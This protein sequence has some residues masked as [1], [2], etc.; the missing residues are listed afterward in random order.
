MNVS[1]EWLRA[2]SGEAIGSPEEIA[3]RLADRGYPVEDTR[4]LSAGLEEVVVAQVRDVQ[5]HPD[6]DRL[7]V[8]QVDGGAGVV[9]VVCGAP[10]VEANGWY[11]F[12]PVGA[13]LPGGMRIRK[14]QLR[15]QPSE[16]MLCSERELGLGSDE[17]GLM[18]LEDSY[19]P[20]QALVA[21]LG[22]DDV[23]LDV[24][25]TPN[26]SDLLSHIGLARELVAGGDASLAL[27]EIPGMDADADAASVK[28]DVIVNEAE[29]N[30]G[31]VT[32]RVEAEDLCPRYL[33]IRLTG[34]SVRPSPRWLQARLRAIGAKPINNVVDATNYLLHESGQ[35]LHAFNLDSVQD[36]TIVVRRA[37]KA[38]ALR[39][40]DRV[41]RRL[42]PEMLAICDAEK[43]IAVAG[44]MGGAD[45][46][47]SDETTDVLLE[48][49]LFAPVS[50]RSTGKAL[51][52]STDASYRFER[53]VDPEGMRNAIERAAR[54][55]VSTA[56]GS[57]SSPLLDVCPRP[58]SRERISLRLARIEQVLGVPFD[59]EAVKSLLE[60]LGL[61]VE[62]GETDLSVEVPGF[63]SYDITREVDLIEEIARTYGYDAFPETLGP[64]RLGSLPDH[65]LFRLESAV[66]AE[67]VASGLLEAQVPAFTSEE[68][69]E[70]EIMNPVSVE[71][72]F[73]RR[74]LLPGLV[75]RLDYNLRRANRDVRLFELGTV[76]RSG[77]T[78]GLPR[79]ET[80]VAAILY[81]QRA[82]T[83]WREG[84]APLDIWDL[85][86]LLE[87]ITKVVADGRWTVRSGP[88]E[89]GSEPGFDSGTLFQVADSEGEPRGAGGRLVGDQL[90]IPRWAEDVWALELALP[91]EP[92]LTPTPT[93]RSL[94]VHQSVDRDLA[95]LIP[96][97]VLVEEVLSLIGERGG[98][99][100]RDIRVFDVY[101][102]DEMPSE[103]RSV[104]VRLRFRASD[105]TLKDE[106]VEDAV[107]VVTRA[108]EEEL[109]VGFRGKQD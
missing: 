17:D 15:G 10:N 33:A 11:P 25:V 58:F 75:G 54:L 65:P 62:I 77:P 26:R 55:I 42:T 9:Q 82:P 59:A 57:I 96:R 23:R 45:S 20:G 63:R 68:G 70:V 84:A 16:G 98:E 91:A 36:R 40:L 6:A 7:R 86:A 69:G 4:Y 93:F 27:P 34:L 44:A 50:I 51:G 52:L 106:E 94:P 90:K 101:R 43:P 19:Q 35:P 49:A 29:V 92:G 32:V 56:G 102:G 88:R 73:L 104:A 81:G 1:V 2:C 76:F 18:V 67:M 66:R 99:H 72:A 60:P 61:S 83:H 46:E 53:G 97:N 78:G 109:S 105:R 8:C 31:G 14:V 64:F 28:V 30:G 107:R 5:P 3:K 74:R 95:L 21:A 39:T 38:E 100:L 13:A 87:R 41:E 24:E 79:E 12:A 22:L 85:K 80:H 108:L 89:N 37:R 71:E 103:V 48:C 47:V